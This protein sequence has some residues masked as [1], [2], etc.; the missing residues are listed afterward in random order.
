M[1]VSNPGTPSWPRLLAQWRL[2]GLTQAE[3]CARRGLSLPAFRYHLYK[4]HHRSNSS[5]RIAPTD[6]AETTPLFLPVVCSSASQPDRASSATASLEVI[7]GDGLRIAVAPG[8]DP[9]TLRRL[10][11]ALRQPSC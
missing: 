4:P 10:V 9:Q 1:A 8:F 2:S 11:E 6:A 3:F 5:G 7:L